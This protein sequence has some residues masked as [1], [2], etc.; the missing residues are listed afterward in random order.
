MHELSVCMSLLEQVAAIAEERSAVRV[1]RIELDIGPLSGVEP[2]LLRNAYP[3][4]ASGTIAEHAELL[5]HVADIVVRCSQC[6]AE[7]RVRANRLV[8]GE[9]GDF[10]TNVRSG[11]EMILRRLELENA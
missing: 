1:T 3:I 11:D 10:R 2:D 8:C 4:A 7:T 9:C 6:D 5:I